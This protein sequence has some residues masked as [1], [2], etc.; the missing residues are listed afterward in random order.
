MESKEEL[1]R[2]RCEVDSSIASLLGWG[3][4]SVEGSPRCFLERAKRMLLAQEAAQDADGVS[5]VNWNLAVSGSPGSG[6]STF[7]SFAQRVLRAYGALSRDPFVIVDAARLSGDERASDIVQAAFVEAAGGG[8]VLI[9]NAH[10]LLAASADS[11]PATGRD[12]VKLIFSETSA[13]RKSV[14]VMLAGGGV[15]MQKLLSS[16]Q[17]NLFPHHVAMPNFT[18]E[19][20]A[21]AIHAR[22]QLAGFSFEETLSARLI[23]HINDSYASP[24]GGVGEV[25]NIHLAESLFEAAQNNALLRLFNGSE[26]DSAAGKVLTA[27]DFKISDRLGPSDEVKEAIDNEVEQLIGMS[28]AKEWFTDLRKKV[29]LVERTGDR[30]I[31][32]MCMNVVITGNPGTGKSTF[33]RLLFRF[34]HAYGICT[35]EVFVEKNGLE[36]KSDHVGGTTPL[37][38]EAVAMAKGGCLFLDEAYAIVDANE[39]GRHGD[40]FSQELVRTLLTEVEN[41]RLGLMVILAG[42]KDKMAHFMRCDPGLERRFPLR[43]HLDDYTALELARICEKVASRQ[44]DKEFEAG[45]L[46]KLAKHIHDYYASDIASQNGGLAVNLTEQAVN[47]LSVRVTNLADGASEMPSD[48]PMLPRRMNTPN[49][50]ALM[51]VLTPADFAISEKPRLGHTEERDRVEREVEG[52]IGMQAAK[53]FF[54]KIK[55]SVLYVENGGNAQILRVCL[56]MVLTGSPGTGKTSVARLL[57]RYLRA[58]GVLTRDRFVEINGLE[59]K[60]QFTG[61]TVHVVKEHIS[62]AMGGTLFIDEAYALVDH[63]GGDRFSMEAIRTLLTEV[64]N[65]RSNLFV[66]L[67]GYKEKMDDLV[68]S[69]PGLA[70]RFSNSLHLANYSAGEIAQICEKVA[71]ERFELA[72]SEGLRAKLEAH[73]AAEHAEDIPEQNAALGI[74]LTEAAFRRLAERHV[75]DDV[76]RESAAGH[77]LTEEDYAVGVPVSRSPRALPRWGTPGEPTPGEDGHNP[78]EERTRGPP[79]RLKLKTNTKTVTPEAAKVAAPRVKAKTAAAEDEDEEEE[80]QEDEDS[81]ELTHEEVLERLKICGTCPQSFEWNPIEAGGERPCGKCSNHFNRDARRAQTSDL[82]SHPLTAGHLPSHP[83]TAEAQTPKA[84]MPLASRAVGHRPT[85][86]IAPSP[87][88]PFGLLDG[89]IPA[90]DGR[91]PVLAGGYRCEGGSHYCCWS[92]IVHAQH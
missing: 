36:L 83:L 68:A 2:R 52:L 16:E 86:R 90:A 58:F 25:G 70:R 11:G 3:N 21:E 77:E 61:Q 64:E 89:R 51:K 59:L 63:S 71:G 8:A 65:N 12:L 37:V 20:V 45:L 53:D 43:L 4:E 40:S 15:A 75:R 55:K 78:S 32:K 87:C 5:D 85:R 22:A 66:V 79:A 50:K 24:D 56:N 54:Q 7:C 60:G 92:C 47:R 18:T 27:E 84:H 44:Y 9:D 1:L 48:G 17:P 49:L 38:K 81:I 46:E 74:N 91:I 31:L 13:H 42:Y 73:I 10:E 82:P 28:S 80:E 26:V 41:N 67:A 19:E 39:P 29:R 14:T 69:D 33:A 30:S 34:L 57:A 76:T 35:R 23:K 62:N 72:F 6:L 88:S